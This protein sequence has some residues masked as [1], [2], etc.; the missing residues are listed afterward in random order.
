MTDY[1]EL[2]KALRD[3][4]ACLSVKTLHEAADAIEELQAQLMF[5]NDAAKAI[6]E[7]VPKWIPVTER[8]PEEEACG[9]RVLCVLRKKSRGW[10]SVDARM[11]QDGDM[12]VTASRKG[13]AWFYRVEEYSGKEGFHYSRMFDRDVKF[14]VPLPEIDAVERRTVVL[15]EVEGK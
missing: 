4:N 2:I 13:D 14:W 11:P 6:A 3:N 9:C 7:K 10:V 12:V 8:L 5:S 15:Q 1:T